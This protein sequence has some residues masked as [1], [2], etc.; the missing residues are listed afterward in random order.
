MATS[1]LLP[2]FVLT[3]VLATWAVTSVAAPTKRVPREPKPGD[4]ADQSAEAAID[5]NDPTAPRYGNPQTVQFRV[6]AEISAVNGACR[7]IIAQVTVPLICAEQK[8]TILSEDFSPEVGEVTY[9]PLAGGEVTQ[10]LISVP[11]LNNGATARAVLTVEV[12]T[13]PVLPPEKTDE[14]T[15]PKKV[16]AKIRTFTN[17]SPYIESNHQKMRALSKEVMK[18]IDESAND[19]AKIEAIYDAVLEKIEY[20]EGPDKGALDALRDGQADCQG[21]SAVFI[22][23]CRAN[24]IPARMVWVHGHCYPEFYLEHAEGEGHWYPCESAGTRAFGEMPLART[25]LQKGDNFRV[26][27]RKEKLRYASDFLTGL[28]TPGGGK[29]KVKYIRELVPGQTAA[30]SGP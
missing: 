15:I 13:R 6:G 23:L 30:F 16:P 7:G 11:R 10:M 25:I 20:V 4:K 1:K 24:K 27:E 21:R 9:R 19:W 12:E 22:A 18:D 3:I 17:A 5:L 2:R 26:P 29:P 8:V 28:P 14:L